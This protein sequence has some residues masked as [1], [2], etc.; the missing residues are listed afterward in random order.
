[1]TTATRAKKKAAATSTMSAQT[2]E[3][4]CQALETEI[5]GVQ[6]YQTAIRCA[7]NADLKEEWEKYLSQTERHVEIVRGIFD[8]LGL[9]PDAESPGREIVRAKGKA[10]VDAMK[11]ALS[12][13]PEAAEIVAAECVVDAETKD[14]A[15]WQLIGAVAESSPD[16]VQEALSTAYD[17][18]EPDEDE[19]LYHT[20][21]WCRELWLES[22]GLEAEIPPPEEEK[23]V[24]SAKDEA[25]AEE[26]RKKELKKAG[27][28]ARRRDGTTAAKKR[29]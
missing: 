10:L 16:D 1:M 11:Q 18:V 15:N 26:K 8:Q 5:G 22:L 28:T 21:G 7:K 4:L 3:L 17:E 27:H 25:K 2:M 12:T 24:H 13:A 19:H 9:D 20:K 14:H 23:D 29:F 6:V